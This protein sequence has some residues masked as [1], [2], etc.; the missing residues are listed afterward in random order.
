MKTCLCC[1]AKL[2]DK[3]NLFC[4]SSRC[5]LAKEKHTRTVQKAW[6]EKNKDHIKMLRERYR[7]R[8]M[9]L[10]KVPQVFKG[11]DKMKGLDQAPRS[12]MERILDKWLDMFSERDQVELIFLESQHLRGHQ[13]PVL[14]TIHQECGGKIWGGILPNRGGRS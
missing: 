8:K 12:I 11:Y 9:H 13:D 4:S 3:R 5:L 6:K 1:G 7:P 2:A 14:A 10:P